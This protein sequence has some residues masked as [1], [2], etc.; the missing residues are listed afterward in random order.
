MFVINA[1]LSDFA[2]AGSAPGAGNG[3][4]PGGAA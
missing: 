4:A 3:M 2:V 1:G